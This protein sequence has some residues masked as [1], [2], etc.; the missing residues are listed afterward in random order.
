MKQRTEHKIYS[1]L[2]R[3]TLVA[4]FLIGIL[5]LFPESVLIKLVHS[6]CQL[7]TAS[8]IDVKENT[9][10]FKAFLN[11]IKENDGVLI[12]GTSETAAFKE[13]NYRTLLNR[14]FSTKKKF[15]YLAGAGRVD[16]IYFPTFL[17]NRSEVENLEVLYFINPTYWRAGL[18]EFSP[19]YYERYN[20]QSEVE[21]V[22]PELEK[23]GI[24]S[25]F[26]PSQIDSSKLSDFEFS[27]ATA[28]KR[29]RLF[30]LPFFQWVHSHTAS[31]LIPSES[32]LCTES[33]EGKFTDT[34]WYDALKL[35]VDTITN[36]TDKYG[37][38]AD[39]E[40]YSIDTGDFQYRALIGFISLC[41]D[42]N[43]RLTCL[44]GPYNNIYCKR[45]NPEYIGDYEEVIRKIGDLLEREKVDYID[46]RDIS[47]MQYSFNDKQH[48]SKY[49]A[50]LLAER[51]ANYY[52]KNR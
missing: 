13:A 29:L 52:E 16:Y 15:S 43:V 32:T 42:M 25:G 39:N 48:H 38:K 20:S 21:R 27:V 12:I 33:F 4:V 3:L 36:S 37:F 22:K 45:T 35:E 44:I 31:D 2:G 19:E 51:I 26:V 49:A 34:T 8:G 40:F 18:N 41:R 10:K 11:G 24:Y 14:Y 9:I 23:R 28:I 6:D 46:A 47:Y 1:G 50:W 17:N 7:C 5:Y 30:Y